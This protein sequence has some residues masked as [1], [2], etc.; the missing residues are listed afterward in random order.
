MGVPMEHELGSF[1][2][3]NSL[4]GI[5]MLKGFPLCYQTGGGRVMNQ[6]NTA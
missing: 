1:L 4:K 6:H 5:H 3:Q 2:P